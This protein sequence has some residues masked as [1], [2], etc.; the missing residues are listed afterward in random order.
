MPDP[1]HH[2]THQPPLVD[3]ELAALNTARPTLPSH[4]RAA[5][6]AI[7]AT[8]A[9]TLPPV[10]VLPAGVGLFYRTGSSQE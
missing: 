8:V 6:Q 5:G 3:P 10:W 1:A 9:P 7:V 4:I 2:R